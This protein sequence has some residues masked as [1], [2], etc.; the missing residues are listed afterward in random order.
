M[1]RRDE[2][3]WDDVADEVVRYIGDKASDPDLRDTAIGDLREDYK[4]A[5]SKKDW[6]TREFNELVDLT[7]ACLREV[8]H[9]YG[10]EGDTRRDIIK[11]AAKKIVDGHF[12]VQVLA[13]DHASSLSNAVY[14]ALRDAKEEATRLERH[15]S[16]DD[17][18]GRD[19]RR[20][21][22][23]D[24]YDRDDRGG[25]RNRSRGRDDR[26]D[27]D[28]GGRRRAHTGDEDDAW[29]VLNDIG[30]VDNDRDERKR[31]DDEDDRD[32]RP[33]RE[34]Y[35][36]PEPERQERKFEK[37][38]IAPLEGPDYSLA[39]PFD[40]WV[41][42]GEHWKAAHL[43]DW[44]LT[45]DVD[46]F[47]ELEDLLLTTIPTLYNV[48][49]HI[50]YYVLGT[51]GSIREEFVE[52]TEENR[53]LAHQLREDDRAPDVTRPRSARINLNGE[54]LDMDAS[55]VNHRQPGLSLAN[56]IEELDYTTVKMNA[57]NM[58]DSLTGIV[59]S[60]QL[61]MMAD[62]GKARIDL[63]YKRTPLVIR[64]R[65]QL[66]LID[67][68][69]DT[70]TLTAAA[71]KLL[72]LRDE[73]EKPVWETLNRRF[74][75]NLLRIA[76]YQFQFNKVAKLNFSNSYGRF[77]AAFRDDRDSEQASMFS[78]RIG[79]LTGMSCAHMLLEQM[80]NSEDLTRNTAGKVDAL[81]FL[82]FIA[83][84]SVN[85]SLDDLGL[86]NAL[87]QRS[88][89]VSIEATNNHR[90]Y[91]E[92]RKIFGKIDSEVP[93]QTRARLLISTSDNRLLEVHPY[94]GEQKAYVLSLVEM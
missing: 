67:Q 80:G 41:E 6:R 57:V 52:V 11:L 49:T 90:L 73:F 20:D 68:V 40:E 92:L 47:S 35:V 55:T 91:D 81:V 33:V 88:T 23:R 37:P 38:P 22:D 24:P 83:M 7:V 59:F 26:D 3:L 17:R 54:G 69:N 58:A 56:Q 27:R 25:R 46:R 60:S 61:D 18:D 74:G 36:E 32:D 28:R 50:K 31:D 82:D 85:A 1:G 65:K 12:A 86:G 16:R 93:A 45:A 42:H 2:G 19:S 72:Q 21:R 43:T 29:S 75:E 84:I 94:F 30:D 8:E 76:R 15:A 13:S 70:T 44:Q 79:V 53:H 87:N 9:E 4:H 89:G 14:D 66:D 51:D 34:R 64:D 5:M 77:L 48:N 78:R 10:R 39:S 63:Y 62:E 71:E